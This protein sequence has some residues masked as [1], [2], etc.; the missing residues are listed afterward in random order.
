M[1]PEFVYIYQNILPPWRIRGKN[2][3]YIFSSVRKSSPVIF[4]KQNNTS[5][6]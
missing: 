4:S 2:I 3:S 5:K 1:V 6:T